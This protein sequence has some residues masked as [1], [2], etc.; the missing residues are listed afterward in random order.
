MS[1]NT[2]ASIE[3]ILTAQNR[4]EKVLSDQT[5]DLARL[6]QQLQAASA[7]A[8]TNAPMAQPL[9]D[10]EEAALKNARRAE[11]IEMRME[12]AF[13]QHLQQKE[14]TLASLSR[15]LGDVRVLQPEVFKLRESAASAATK[16]EIMDKRVEEVG[17]ALSAD[18]QRVNQRLG[19]IEGSVEGAVA[20]AHAEL[21]KRLDDL[22][23]DFCSSRAEAGE[24][25]KAL[26]ESIAGKVF[27]VMESVKE[28]E[29]NLATTSSGHATT[30]Q[31]LTAM[32]ESLFEMQEH[33][34][35]VKA[36]SQRV[37]NAV[38][39]VHRTL[40]DMCQLPPQLVE[41]KELL[42]THEALLAEVTSGL[43]T[44]RQEIRQLQ[45]TA[46]EEAKRRASAAES[47]ERTLIDKQE[48]MEVAL[49]EAEVLLLL[50]REFQT[51]THLASSDRYDFGMKHRGSLDSTGTKRRRSWQCWRGALP[52]L[53]KNYPSKGW[54]K[55]SL[56]SL[57]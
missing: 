55:P 10:I 4:L 47:L 51:F 15:C 5:E 54:A 30:K 37:D 24:R 36:R 27:G 16:L 33:L 56:A 31:S 14:A 53:L 12:E 9:T 19:D 39:E 29:A 50:T 17:H 23:S 20:A 34:D 35:H 11:A 40:N 41:A 52:G 46:A 26:E 45:T 43:L 48:D 22:E 6:S 44:S 42:R 3:M 13:Q 49:R 28:I 21:K 1:E 38:D 57:C 18:I 32:N 7:K 25:S 8:T 2:N